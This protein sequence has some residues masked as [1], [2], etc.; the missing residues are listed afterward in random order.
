MCLEESLEFYK[1]S[2]WRMFS[3]KLLHSAGPDTEKAACD[4]PPDCSAEQRANTDQ[5][6]GGYGS[7]SMVLQDL[8][9]IW[10]QARARQKTQV[11][12]IYTGH[13]Q[14]TGSQCNLISTGVICWCFRC[15]AISLAAE[16]CTICNMVMSASVMPNN[17]ALP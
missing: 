11:L 13:A 14:R 10:V 9:C 12:V 3:G 2:D 6:T 5:Q 8:E 4:S 17:T 7:A 16:F 1:R 15:H